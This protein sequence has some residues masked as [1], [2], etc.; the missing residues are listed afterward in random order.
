MLFVCIK[1]HRC[2]FLSLRVYPLLH[3]WGA[4]NT[5]VKSW[6]YFSIHYENTPTL[7]IG[8]YRLGRTC[9]I[10]ISRSLMRPCG[11]E[12]ARS[13]KPLKNSQILSKKPK[14]ERFFVSR[15]FKTWWSHLG[16]KNLNSTGS[17]RPV[18]PPELPVG[19]LIVKLWWFECFVLIFLINSAPWRL[20]DNTR[21]HP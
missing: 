10:R 15:C 3:P 12:M 9:R 8:V 19:V 7:H 13:Q 21:N 18:D 11:F 6:F 16:P 20:F 2:E 4:R 17:S 1:K 14:F 5:V